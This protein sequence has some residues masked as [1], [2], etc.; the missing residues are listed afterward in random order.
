MALTILQM[1]NRAET[2]LG[3]E[4]SSTVFGASPS[5]TAKQMGALANRTLDELR[6]MNRWTVLQFEYNIVVDTPLI[7]TGDMAANSAVITNIPNTSTLAAN[8]WAVSGDSIPTAARI[9]S[10]DSLTQVT[11]TMENTSTSAVTGATITFAKDMY[12]LPSD[13][14][15]YNNQT[16]WDRTNDWSLVGPDS[17][18]F[19]QALRSGITPLAPRRRWRQL[20]PYANR[21]RIWPPP[22]EI[23]SPAQLVFEYLSENS[24]NV[25]GAGTSFAKYFT[26]DSDTCL[27]DDDALITGI[28]WMFWEIK[29][30]GS[31]VTLQNRWIDYINRLAARDAGAPKLNMSRRPV[32]HLISS[33][34]VQDGN[35]PSS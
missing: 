31:Y 18:Q 16:M 26:A 6:R 8:F 25:T 15:Y 13:F 9:L 27:L 22:I 4:E 34:N 20:G 33:D 17:P 29:G 30:M 23:T 14:D 5:L 24:V 2:E 7:T 32:S 3:L 28:K 35:F 12:P 21:F 1:V 11:M 10:V 19:D